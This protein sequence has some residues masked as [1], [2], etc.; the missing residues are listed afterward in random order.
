MVI[1]SVDD[2]AGN[3]PRIDHLVEKPAPRDAPSTLGVVG[4]YLLT[5]RIIRSRTEVRSLAGFVAGV[6]VLWSL[7]RL[8][9]GARAVAA[10]RRREVVGD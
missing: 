3:A 10:L 7:G 8:L 2:A 4:R 9:D 1:P 6:A 5:P